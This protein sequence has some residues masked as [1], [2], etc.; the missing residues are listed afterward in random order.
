MAKTLIFLL[1]VLI[2]LYMAGVT[3]SSVKHSIDQANREHASFDN[4][5]D[6]DGWAR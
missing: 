6:K 3:P 4:R 2:G 5:L 1:A